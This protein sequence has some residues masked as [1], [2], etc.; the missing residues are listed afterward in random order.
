MVI[1]FPPAKRLFNR[2]WAAGQL[3]R[4]PQTKGKKSNLNSLGTLWLSTNSPILP[5][6][7][8]PL[9]HLDKSQSFLGYTLV[10]EIYSF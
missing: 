5:S 4:H 7:Q 9:Q 1:S 2:Q 8:H 10:G 6:F 3:Q